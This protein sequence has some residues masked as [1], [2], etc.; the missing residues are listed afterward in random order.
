MMTCA[1]YEINGPQR[2]EATEFGV[3][4]QFEKDTFAMTAF[5]LNSAKLG[6]DPA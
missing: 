6:F 2:M 4:K 3:S 1:S 5:K